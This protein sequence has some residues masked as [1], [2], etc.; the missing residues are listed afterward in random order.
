MTVPDSLSV[1]CRTNRSF[2]PQDL[3]A[4]LVLLTTLQ[5]IMMNPEEKR[6]PVDIVI[7][8][9]RSFSM[10][11]ANKLELCK[12]TLAFLCKE[13]L[14][15][16]D[17]LGLVVFD[18]DVQVIYPC[19][20]MTE[21][22]KDKFLS[23]MNAV[24]VG[25]HTNLSAGLFQGL[26]LLKSIDQLSEVSAVLVLSDGAMTTGITDRAKLLRMTANMVAS[27][28]KSQCPPTIHCFGYG[29]NYDQVLVDMAQN[30]GGMFY[31]VANV[32]H[33]PL[34]F[35]DTLG[36]LLHVA[37][38]NICISIEVSGGGAELV[39]S[40]LTKCNRM[41]KLSGCAW[42]L[43]VRDIYLGERK[44][45][46]VK[47]RL[48]KLETAFSTVQCRVL[49]KYM[50]VIKE[51]VNTLSTMASIS[52]LVKG[53]LE[54]QQPILRD[55]LEVARQMIR[56]DA[57]NALE[58]ARMTAEKGDVVSSESTI[59]A[60]LLECTRAMGDLNLTEAA[61]PMLNDVMSDLRSAQT[62]FQQQQRASMSA[63][64][65][66]STPAAT[67]LQSVAWSH[68]NQRANTMNDLFGATTSAFGGAPMTAAPT[69]STSTFS[70]NT[71]SKSKMLK[72]AKDVFGL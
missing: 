67:V 31:H 70:Y 64:A 63:K 23:K 11:E 50:D 52:R 48:P 39:D 26:D 10:L 71:E 57:V 69:T 59:K 55:D 20:L 37:A 44:D 53:D 16:K 41:E 42:N 9:D 1:Q 29:D 33:I 21:K 7:V 5:A 68:A 12:K 36:G 43:H 49:V 8:L 25:D 30:N 72:K 46:L 24:Q 54:K 65:F 66:H 19:D 4:E 60:S 17:R 45:I 58:Q 27:F 15:E 3:D 6:N 61:D 2:V 38:Q 13:V 32:E 18:S 28:N 56:I 51:N 62:L 14:T 47:M 40:P 34:A 22:N 35:A